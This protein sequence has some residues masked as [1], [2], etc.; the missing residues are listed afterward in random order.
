M[1]DALGAIG[2]LLVEQVDLSC[3]VHAEPL[4]LSSA[5]S[6]AWYARR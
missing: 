2:D 3:C 4:A 6:I 1:F 5:L